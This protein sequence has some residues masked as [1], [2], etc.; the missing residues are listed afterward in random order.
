[1]SSTLL[2]ADAAALRT[3]SRKRPHISYI[4]DEHFDEDGIDADETTQTEDIYDYEDEDDGTYGKKR[5]SKTKRAKVA[6]AF[7]KPRKDKKVKPFRFLDLSAE[8]RNRIYEFALVEPSELT[9]V[10]RTKNYR[11]G[12]VRGAID[13][14]ETSRH[15]GKKYRYRYY[16]W[17]IEGH[18]KDESEEPKNDERS[19]VPNLLAVNRQIREE[20][21]S[22]LYK[23][24]LILEDT[25]ALHIF[26]ACIG[27]SNRELL[28]DV[29]IRGWGVGR[30]TMKGYN[31]SALT[32]LQG[33]TNL[34]SLRFECSLDRYLDSA[35]L[36]RQI[37]RDGV[38]FLEAIGDAQGR[39]DA[40]VDVVQLGDWHF[41]PSKRNGWYGKNTGESAEVITQKRR[42]EFEAELRRLL[43]RGA[44]R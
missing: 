31:F 10:A 1:M 33:C 40:A 30:G 20:A 34:Q 35:S 18:D 15:Y 43:A 21:S 8:L 25:N 23:Q 22:Y 39:Y 19:L 13:V 44:R 41:D 6:R 29:T 2:A 14:A 36:A 28:T 12:I 11:R 26:L 5:T 9:L 24:E 42:S 17:R 27:P 37:Y 3:S 4:E 32:M 38:F 16:D 7:A